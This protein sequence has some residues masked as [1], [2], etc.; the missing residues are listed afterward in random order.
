MSDKYDSINEFAIVGKFGFQAVRGPFNAEK[1]GKVWEIIVPVESHP[2][3]SH[4]DKQE[5]ESIALIADCEIVGGGILSRV[6]TSDERGEKY[7]YVDQ[8]VLGD[9]E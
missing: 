4:I 8:Y 1:D 7:L 5:G 3:V 6:V 9:S 2:T